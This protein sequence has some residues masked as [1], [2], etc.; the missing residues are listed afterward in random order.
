[1]SDPKTVAAQ[2]IAI[3]REQL[4]VLSERIH[5]NPELG[6]Q[7][8]RASG[9]V[10]EIL[11]GAGFTVERPYLGFDTALRASLGTGP[12]TVGLCAEYDALPGLG[13]ACGHNLI[14][15]MSVGAALALA[16]V[17]DE[18]GLTVVLYGTPAE[19][20]LGGK[21]ELLERGAFRELDLALM[22]HPAPQDDPEPAA[23]AVS[24]SHISYRG[25]A[26]HAAGAPEQGINAAD[27]FTIAQT[28][29]GLLRQH[30]PSTVRVHGVV[31][32][33][34]EAPNAIAEHTEGRWYVRAETL[35]E[36][37]RTE[38]R[39]WK[40]F[41]A[42]ALATG[43]TLEITPESRPYS[44]MRTDQRTLGLYRANLEQ[45]GRVIP[46]GPGTMSRASTDFANVSQIVDAIHP[47]IGID[48]WPAVNHQ[49]EFAAAC[50]GPIAEQALIDGATA[51]AWTAI[52]RFAGHAD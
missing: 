47:Y 1:M 42:G 40:C 28:A 6:W 31:T 38:E 7:E 39:V 12:H 4:V 35:D 51:L 15:A 34:G 10:E 33:A 14:S 23:L 13:H 36:L 18:V 30:L 19:E 48:S 3:R 32:N 41:E 24:H 25:K 50:V 16:A 11:S 29:I 26:A 45:L 5:A 9:W 17:A 27:A 44:E 20:G 49:K 2:E 37:R 21:C 52:D 46:A 43:C 22:A 8:H